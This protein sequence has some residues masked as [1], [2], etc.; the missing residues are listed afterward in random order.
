MPLSSQLTTTQLPQKYA[1]FARQCP[2]FTF[3]TNQY[4][5]VVA[6]VF[7]TVACHE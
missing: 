7:L 3:E 6:D 2:R 1:L 5:Y 4:V